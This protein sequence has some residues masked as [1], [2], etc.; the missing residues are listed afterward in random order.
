[1]YM[2]TCCPR[3]DNLLVDNVHQHYACFFPFFS[4]IYDASTNVKHH[5]SSQVGFVRFV[6]TIL[7]C[8]SVS[9][10]KL[11]LLPTSHPIVQPPCPVPPAKLEISTDRV[12]CFLFQ[13]KHLIKP[14]MFY[15]FRCSVLAFRVGKEL[16]VLASASSHTHVQAIEYL[17]YIQLSGCW[18]CLRLVLGSFGC[19]IDERRGFPNVTNA[20]ATARPAD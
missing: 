3:V 7:Q 10:S 11:H 20:L 15:M 14:N 6:S 5:S 4:S 18:L 12:F 17:F 16:F 13:Y 8:G 19:S 2:L 9:Y 1:M